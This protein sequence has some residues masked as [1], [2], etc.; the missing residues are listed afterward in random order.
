MTEDCKDNDKIEAP[1]TQE[2]VDALNRWQQAGFVHEFTCPS[3]HPDRTLLA[4]PEGWA[5]QQCTYRQN[6]AHRFMLEKPVNPTEY[7]RG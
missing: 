2:Q 1:W 3:D 5:C 7:F 6:W 4:T